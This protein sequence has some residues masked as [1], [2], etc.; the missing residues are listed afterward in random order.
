MPGGKLEFHKWHA[1][2][3][4]TGFLLG[5]AGKAPDQFAGPLLF[6]LLFG[7]PFHLFAGNVAAILDDCGALD[8]AFPLVFAHHPGRLRFGCGAHRPTVAVIAA[9]KSQ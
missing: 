1:R 7:H 5:K 9:A 3:L 2:I 8:Q 4:S 6:E